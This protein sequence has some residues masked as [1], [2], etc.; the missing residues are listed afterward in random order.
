MGRTERGRGGASEVGNVQGK[1]GAEKPRRNGEVAGR[2]QAGGGEGGKAD[3][4]GTS[5]H[6]IR[7]HL[8]TK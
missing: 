6:G 8:I 4:A 7:H 1:G 2:A 3:D 5:E